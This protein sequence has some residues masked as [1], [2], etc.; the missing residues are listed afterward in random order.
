MLVTPVATWLLAKGLGSLL[1]RLFPS[2]EPS[3][4]ALSELRSL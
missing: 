1:V 2:T 4:V 3:T